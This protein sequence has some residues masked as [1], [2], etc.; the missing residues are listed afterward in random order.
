MTFRTGANGDAS[1]PVVA[2]IA[3][4]APALPDGVRLVFFHKQRTSARL[5]FLLFADGLTAPEPL[6]ADA[7]FLAE[8]DATKKV[9]LHPA[10]LSL[11]SARH[12]GLDRAALKIDADFR[13][14]GEDRGTSFTLL[15]AEFTDIDPPFEAAATAGARFVAITDA[16]GLGQ[17][18]R[19]ALRLAYSH[20]L[21]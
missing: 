3:S 5:R 19:E 16:R 2:P 10:M 12:F 11:E 8:A 7:V 20:L 9:V 4:G 18:E 17:A 13:V 15:L 21:G 6:T 14:Q 1:G